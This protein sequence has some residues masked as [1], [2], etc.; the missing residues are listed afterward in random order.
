MP[1]SPT[2]PLHGPS[3]PRNM[4]RET[5]MSPLHVHVGPA[6][7]RDLAGPHPA[8]E[9]EDEDH[10]V[11]GRELASAWRSSSSCSPA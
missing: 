1:T 2:V 6:Q 8:L 11:L 10:D 7:R 9:A 4:V 3:F 5:V